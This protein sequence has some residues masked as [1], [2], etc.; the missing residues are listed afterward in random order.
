STFTLNY[1][2]DDGVNWITIDISIAGNQRK[3]K[4]KTPNIATD[5]AR[6]QLINNSTGAVSTSNAFAILGIPGVIFDAVQCEGY[7]KIKWGAV[8]SATDYEVFMLRGDDMQS[9][10]T[11][12]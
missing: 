6:I 5:K 1:S 4:M 8:P 2:T 9:M 10:A 7:I 3:E 12:A 11:T